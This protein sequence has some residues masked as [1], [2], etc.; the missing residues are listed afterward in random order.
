MQDAESSIV[1][2][3]LTEPRDEFLY[4]ELATADRK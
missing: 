2:S 3:E 4:H 1:D